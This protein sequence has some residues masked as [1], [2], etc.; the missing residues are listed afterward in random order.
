MCDLL[1]REAL[2]HRRRTWS[3]G[4]RGLAS[5]RAGADD[6]GP[7]K[8]R[9]QDLVG[10]QALQGRHGLKVGVAP[11]KHNAINQMHAGTPCLPEPDGESAVGAPWDWGGTA[12]GNP[13]GLWDSDQ[14]FLAVR[15]GLPAF[16]SATPPR[17]L[18]GPR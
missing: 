18:A 3:T 14:G 7:G 6:L 1:H 17:F 9:V 16:L 2:P 8:R 10:S 13:L 4:S 11:L 5:T 15:T 12:D